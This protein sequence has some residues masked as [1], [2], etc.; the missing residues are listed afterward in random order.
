[1]R[2]PN[3]I[4]QDYVNIST[5]TLIGQVKVKVLKYITLIKIYFKLYT[6]IK[7]FLKLK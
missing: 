3:M 2:K 5:L 7:V 4:I 6:L 1:M